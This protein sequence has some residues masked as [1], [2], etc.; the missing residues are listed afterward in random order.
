M[1]TA[2]S[3]ARSES[4]QSS[5]LF[6][7]F[8]VS[9]L[10]FC[11]DVLQVQEVLKYQPMT[12]VPQA[13]EAVEG[14]INLRGQIVTAIEMRRRLGLP[15]RPEEMAPMNIVVSTTDGAVSLLVDE[16]GDVMELSASDY[17]HPP[18]NIDQ[19]AFDVIKGVYKLR[20]KLLLVLDAE[21]IADLSKWR[22]PISN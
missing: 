19:S 2:M 22:Q 6:S 3:I 1:A 10:S 15:P 14:L 18:A 7:T 5:G 16:I 13:P 11:I 8:L 4:A 17:E 21:R 12:P 9:D 20:D